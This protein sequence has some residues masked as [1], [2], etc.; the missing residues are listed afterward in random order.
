MLKQFMVTHEQWKQMHISFIS[1]SIR[2]IFIKNIWNKNPQTERNR[3]NL[4][5]TLSVTFSLRFIIIVKKHISPG[6]TLISILLAFIK[7]ISGIVGTALFISF[8]PEI[9]YGRMKS[10]R[11]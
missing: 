11:R 1:V 5:L 3:N 9:T 7:G 8:R 6:W 10:K 4:T 2:S